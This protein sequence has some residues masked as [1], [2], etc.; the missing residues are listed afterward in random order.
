MDLKRAY[1]LLYQDIKRQKE[2]DERLPLT[3]QLYNAILVNT[4]S[5]IYSQGMSHV[6]R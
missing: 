4:A 2:I 1:V 3:K 6:E 5:E